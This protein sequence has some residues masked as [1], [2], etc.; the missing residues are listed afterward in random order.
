MAIN[1]DVA[2]KNI[3]VEIIHGA[4]GMGYS[5]ERYVDIDGQFDEVKW[6]REGQIRREGRKGQCGALMR[7]RTTSCHS[8]C[9][10][11]TKKG[12][13]QGPQRSP[14]GQRLWSFSGDTLESLT[15]HTGIIRKKNVEQPRLL[16]SN[17]RCPL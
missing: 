7:Q 11:T 8:H 4:G 16:P 15:H 12:G 17:E 13:P 14:G 5:Q 9:G 10:K 2:R 1:T 3:G 6:M